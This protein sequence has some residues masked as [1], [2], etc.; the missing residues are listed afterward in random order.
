M[1]DWYLAPMLETGRT[2][3]NRRWPNRD[4]ASDGTIGDEAHQG[5][6][7]DHNPNSRGSVNAWD[8]DVN[9]VDIPEILSAFERLPGAH[10]WIYNRRIADADNDWRPVQYTG[11]NPHTLH[12]HLS[13]RQSVLA[14]QDTRPWGIYPYREEDL[15]PQE[16]QMLRDIKFAVTSV[17]KPDG[18]GDTHVSGGVELLLR[19][20]GEILRQIT[21]LHDQAI[22]LLS[23][24]SQIDPVAFAAALAASPEALAALTSAMRDQ[25]P[26]IP[27]AQEVAKAVL[28]WISAGVH[29]GT[30][31]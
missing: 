20:Q 26:L 23:G 6:R 16:S 15:T 11:S 14:E 28:V 2:E 5:T 1:V 25:L 12:A 7:S 17:T 13:I 21:A 24:V 22:N 29:N 31:T 9:G 4:K 3:V 18:T 10:Y 8:I 27:T 19:G 30:P